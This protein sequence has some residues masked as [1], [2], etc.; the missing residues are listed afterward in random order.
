MIITANGRE[1]EVHEHKAG[2]KYGRGSDRGKPRYTVTGVNHP[3]G[4]LPIKF[5]SIDR[6]ERHLRNITR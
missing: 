4:K 1:F 3:A 5:K 6:A 2:H